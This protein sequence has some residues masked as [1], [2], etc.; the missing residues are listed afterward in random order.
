MKISAIFASRG[1]KKVRKGR[2]AGPWVTAR[3]TVQYLALL[4]FV[5]LFVQ[6]QR[7]GWPGN[8]VNLPMR[9]DPLIVLGHLLASRTFL[10]GSAVALIVVLLTLVF[11]RAWCGWLCPLGTTLD[12][13]PLRRWRGDRP[14]PAEG[15]RKVKYLLLVATL[16]A[17]L[18]GNLALLFFDPLALWFRSLTVALW[19]AADRLLTAAEALLYRIPALAG[20]VSTFDGWIRPLLFPTAPAFYRD[21]LL[22]AGIFLGVILLNL[23]APRSWCRYLC[24]LGGLLG[25]LGKVAL[26]RRQVD[27]ECKGCTLCTGICPTGTIDPARGYRSDPGEC[28]VCMD[29]VEVCPRGL[30]VFKPGL[31]PA[32]WQPYDPGRREAL[33]TIGAAVAGVA[34][35]RSGLLARREPPFLL[36]PPGVRE[37]NPDPAAFTKC[38]RCGECLRACPTHALQP[39]VFDAG[40]EGLGSP[41]FVMRLGFCD[42]S[43]TACGQA[44]P[45]Q[46]IPPLGLEQKRLQVVGLATIDQNRCIPWSDHKPCIVC[47][48]M[49]PLPDKAVQLEQAEIQEADGTRLTLQLPRVVRDLCIGCG[50]CEYQCPVNGEAAIRVYV[51][52][53]STQF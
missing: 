31:L 48:E 5:V 10:A 37:T 7:D 49:C 26:F 43:C 11:G 45:V 42:Y 18:L 51:P 38:T 6:A 9:L 53:A 36:R 21:A 19:P 13:F 32:V 29:C 24:P 2:P 46:A 20:P 35:L 25:L 40:L 52:E 30:N 14:A 16:V 8:V 34:L 1:K 47:Q 39:S 33:V 3:K 12:L 22:F 4:I 41:V 44:C 23:L 28:T 50:I 17:A 15:W 27:E